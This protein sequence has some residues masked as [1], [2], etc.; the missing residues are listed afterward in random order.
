MIARREIAAQRR[1]ATQFSIFASRSAAVDRSV[2]LD[3]R[4]QHLG[5]EVRSLDDLL[6]GRSPA[7]LAL[8]LREPAPGS[9]AA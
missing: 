6:V 9:S 5:D 8:F 3:E 2:A 7:S 1:I 4:R